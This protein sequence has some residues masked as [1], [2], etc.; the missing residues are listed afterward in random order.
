MI[1]DREHDNHREIKLVGRCEVVQSFMYLGSL[2]DNSGSCKNEIRRRIQQA[3][4]NTKKLTKIWQTWT[5]KKAD[6]ASI[7]AFEMWTC[8]R[9]LR[10]PYTAHGT[11]VSILDGLGNPK[12]LSSI[13]STRMRT[14][15]EHIHRSDNIEKLVVQGRKLYGQLSKKQLH[16]PQPS[17]KP[18]ATYALTKN[19]T[20]N[21]KQLSGV[22]E[23][24]PNI[25]HIYKQNTYAGKISKYTDLAIEIK[26]LWK[27]N[28]VT[29]VPLIMSVSDLTP[30]TFT[31]HLQQLGLDEKL[32]KVF[33]NP[34]TLVVT[35]IMR[36]ELRKSDNN[37][38][39][40]K[41]TIVPLI[42]SVSGLTPNTFTP[43]LKQLGLDERL[44]K[45]FQKSV[46]L[47]TCN[48]VRSFLNSDP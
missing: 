16:S 32:H 8:R 1:V 48:I 29:I 41:V 24:A 9:M 6:R 22:S 10:V 27:Q 35:A 42:M 39:Q 25:Q 31:Q 44:H 18:R 7:D 43:H 5:V 37:S 3:S 40:N 45:I 46:I 14:F 36:E 28:R 12:R 30:N 34:S 38:K 19:V 26:R 15:F 33:Q 2:I 23:A 21:L 11:N 4:V 20:S 47:K 13:E 17:T